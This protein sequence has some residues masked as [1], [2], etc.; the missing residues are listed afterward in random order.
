MDPGQNPYTPNAGARPPAL[1]GRDPEIEAFDVLLARV[2]RGRAEQ[3]LLVTGLRGVGKTVLLG[4]FQERARLADWVSIDTEIT[5]TTRFGN[6]M[7]H[8]VK[9]ALLDIAPAKRWKERARR[10]GRVLQSFS[11]TVTTEGSITGS[12]DLEPLAG[13]ADSG[14]LGED[15]TDLFVALGEA[16]A[17]HDR[18]VVFLLDEVQFL[19]T[20]EFEALIAGLHRTVQRQLPIT[21]VGAGLPQLP[22]L[23]GEAK[24][25]A[26]RLFK[27][28]RIGQLSPPQ[29]EAALAEP[30]AELS[31]SYEPDAIDIIVAYTEGYPY[32]LQEYGKIV[33]DLAPEGEPISERITE[34]AQRAV[35]AKLDESFF[36]VRAE[37]VTELELHYLRAMA[38]LGPGE[39]TAGDVAAVMGRR[40]EQLGPTRARL[41]DKGLLYTTGHGRG[42]FTVPQFDRYMR[43]NHELA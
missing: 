41:I 8:L 36:R 24:S 32:F 37:R 29:A 12:L 26:E 6:R 16:A 33:W 30:A 11:V 3:S 22:R 9:R 15:L 27:F 1:V 38:A 42:A 18:G 5:R 13:A 34:E 17:D 31:V 10:A 28:P 35:E 20:A 40:T 2:R 14:D 4:E 43:R 19:A 25:Y 7:A 39:Q 21:L 23:A